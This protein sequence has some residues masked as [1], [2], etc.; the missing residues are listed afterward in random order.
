MVSYSSF[1]AFLEYRTYGFTVTL[2]K[3]FCLSPSHSKLA[4]SLISR[5]NFPTGYLFV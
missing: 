4:S 5:Y 2:M 3:T 1:G